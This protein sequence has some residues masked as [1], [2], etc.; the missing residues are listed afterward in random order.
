MWCFQKISVSRLYVKKRRKNVP[1]GLPLAKIN[2]KHTQKHQKCIFFK[3]SLFSRVHIKKRRNGE[4]CVFRLNFSTGSLQ[5][6]ST[7]STKTHQKIFL[8]VF[9]FHVCTQKNSEMVCNLCFSP[10]TFHRDDPSAIVKKKNQK[11]EMS[12]FYIVS[13]SRPYVYKRQNETNFMHFTLV[14]TFFAT[15]TILGRPCQKR[16]QIFDCGLFRNVPALE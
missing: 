10:K 4:I 1:Q 3:L 6:K 2:K 13:I 9:H 16:L 14:P 15:G 8:N 11:S 7:K 12:F 5:Q